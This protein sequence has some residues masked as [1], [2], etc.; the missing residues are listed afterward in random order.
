MSARKALAITVLV[1]VVVAGCGSDRDARTGST[2][3]RS[4]SSTNTG[5]TG[6]TV[7]RPRDV[8]VA[9]SGFSEYEATDVS[10]TA[11]AVVL[12]NPNPGWAA[13]NVSL[14][15]TF[16]GADGQE[17]GR[18]EETIPLLLPGEMAWAREQPTNDLNPGAR[19]YG[20]EALDAKVTVG[21]WQ[22]LDEPAGTLEV[23]TIEMGLDGAAIWSVTAPVTSSW[24]TDLERPVAVAVFRDARGKLLGG[25]R[26]SEPTIPANGTANVTVE[27]W[28]DLEGV[29]KAE[30]FVS[31]SS[32]PT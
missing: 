11:W 17:L 13:T 14:D 16:T 22:R 21:E 28:E 8:V 19:L 27:E 25:A 18:V 4:T 31:P 2:V 1:V 3:D 20:A 5:S 15:L 24:S 23:G 29:D 30:L 6:T 26:E 32:L 7:A 10:Y 9:E 12:D